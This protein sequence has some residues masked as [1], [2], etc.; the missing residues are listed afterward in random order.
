MRRKKLWWSAGS[1]GLATVFWFTGDR[2]LAVFGWSMALLG[3]GVAYWETKEK[4]PP[5]EPVPGDPGTP[6]LP[7]DQDP[8]VV[9]ATARRVR[10]AR[11]IAVSATAFAVASAGM[12]LLPLGPW[13][14]LFIGWALLGAAGAVSAVTDSVRFRKRLPSTWTELEVL[15]PAAAEP[16]RLARTP[17]GSELAFK[18]SDTDD[19][20]Q[21]HIEETGVLR[22][23]G[24]PRVGGP[25]RIAIPGERRLGLATFSL[26]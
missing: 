4:T 13:R 1:L 23:L 16:W 2:Q 21:R 17:D 3:L 9:A 22:V 20:L 15:G 12:A 6:A 10:D 14:N 26:P 11:R 24:E 8:V 19:V 18:L 25:V 7:P 5:P